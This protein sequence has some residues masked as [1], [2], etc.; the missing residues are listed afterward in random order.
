MQLGCVSDD[1]RHA[2]KKN[3]PRDPGVNQFTVTV[4]V[5]VEGAA[6]DAVPEIVTT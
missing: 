1:R 6:F 2:A 5:V 3:G 4:T